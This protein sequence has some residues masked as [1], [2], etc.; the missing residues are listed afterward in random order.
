MWLPPADRKLPWIRCSQDAT[1][2]NHLKATH[3]LEASGLLSLTS[4]GSKGW[5]RRRSKGRE[6]GERVRRRRRRSGRRGRGGGGEARGGQEEE[7]AKEELE[8]GGGAEGAPARHEVWGGA[9]WARA[10]PWARMAVAPRLWRSHKPRRRSAAARGPSAAEAAA[11]HPARPVTHTSAQEHPRARPRDVD[12]SDRQINGGLSCGGQASFRR[13]MLFRYKFGRTPT[14]FG[15]E[16]RA[17]SG[18]NHPNIGRAQPIVCP[19]V[20]R[21]WTGFGQFRAI[22]DKARPSSAPN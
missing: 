1:Q 12:T 2:T 5:R 7:E 16:L 10:C 6:E 3:F 9:P 20:H 22:S 18:R 21:L 17:I 11:P 8:Q 14:E 19:D 15:T 4:I 13:D